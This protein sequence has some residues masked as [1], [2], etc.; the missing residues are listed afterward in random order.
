[1]EKRKLYEPTIDYDKE[2][3][4]IENIEVIDLFMGSH[5]TIKKFFCNFCKKFEIKKKF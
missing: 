1:M 4:K 3:Y 5:R 2:K